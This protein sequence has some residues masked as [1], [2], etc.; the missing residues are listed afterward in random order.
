MPTSVVG[1]I[2]CGTYTNYKRGK[3]DGEIQLNSFEARCKQ[4][5]E[6]KCGVHSMGVVDRHWKPLDSTSLHLIW[7]AFVRSHSSDGTEHRT[8]EI[9]RPACN[10]VLKEFDLIHLRPH[11]A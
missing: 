8:A 6:C 4:N 7:R 11:V 9:S 2:R 10:L 1:F 5:G 3:S